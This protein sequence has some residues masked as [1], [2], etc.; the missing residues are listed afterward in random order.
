MGW[1]G[2]DW[3]DRYVKVRGRVK[4]CQWIEGE[5]MNGDEE[6]CGKETVPGKPYCDAHCARAYVGWGESDAA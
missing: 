2:R 3:F 5:P 6:R 1:R 4:S